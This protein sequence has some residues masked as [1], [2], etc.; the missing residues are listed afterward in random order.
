M[1]CRPALPPAPDEPHEPSASP[2]PR[3]RAS[4][5]P[6]RESPTTPR[7]RSARPRLRVWRSFALVDGRP[8]LRFGL[9]ALKEILGLIESGVLR[10]EFGE[11]VRFR[12]VDREVR[13]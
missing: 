3:C 6:F 7:I 13:R 9:A 1:A 5:S 12:R 8:P 2:P 10:V 11:G 4:V